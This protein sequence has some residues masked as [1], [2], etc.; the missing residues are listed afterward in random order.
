MISPTGIMRFSELVTWLDK[1][2]TP[3]EL[4]LAREVKYPSQNWLV[5][6]R[7]TGKVVTLVIDDFN[8]E[9]H[10]TTGNQK[11][12]THVYSS[13]RTGENIIKHLNGELA[14]ISPTHY[15]EENDR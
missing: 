3:N 10:Y 12:K 14:H 15:G 9:V 5:A 1:L 8:C 2:D 13:E 7:R 11:W 4:T 6:N